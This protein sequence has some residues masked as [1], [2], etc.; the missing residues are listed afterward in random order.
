M[1]SVE[2]CDL[3]EVSNCGFCS[4]VAK[5]HDESLERGWKPGE[6]VIL[7]IIPGATV[8]FSRF[9]GSCVGCGRR[10]EQGDPIFQLFKSDNGWSATAC[11]AQ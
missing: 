11:C 3:H 9:G 2:P 7:P 8:M 6:D 4:G 1:T 10:Y 5:K